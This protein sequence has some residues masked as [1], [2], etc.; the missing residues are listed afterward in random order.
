[1]FFDV[2][3]KTTNSSKKTQIFGPIVKD[4]TLQSIISY[5]FKRDCYEFEQGTNYTTYS[6]VYLSA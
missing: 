1:M 6:V 5:F 2:L 4:V 3:T